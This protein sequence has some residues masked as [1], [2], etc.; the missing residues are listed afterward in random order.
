[1]SEP[2]LFFSPT[3][4]IRDLLTNFTKNYCEKKNGGE[5]C[6][7]EEHFEQVIPYLAKHLRIF[8]VTYHHGREHKPQCYT[9]LEN[10]R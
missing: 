5:N 7:E 8:L 3:K 4:L 6:N 2:E 1:M 9:E 10:G